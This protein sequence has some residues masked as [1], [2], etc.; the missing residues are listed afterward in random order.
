MWREHTH[1]SH[2]NNRYRQVA[3]CSSCVGDRLCMAETS[4]R[5]VMGAAQRRRQRRLRSWHGHEQQIARIALATFAHH[6]ALR[7]QKRTRAREE[8]NEVHFTATILAN[9]PHQPELFS[10]YEEEPGGRRPASLAEPPGPQE[11]IQRRTVEQPAELAPDPRCSCSAD[12]RTAGGQPP[13]LR[14]AVACCQAGY[15]RAQELPRGH[16]FATLVS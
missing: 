2:N 10:L 3:R 9:P 1:T 14:C 7:G 12:G 16:P 11:R 8:D 5:P 6:S 15:R 13:F 4:W